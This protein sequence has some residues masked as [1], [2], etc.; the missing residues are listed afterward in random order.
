MFELGKLRTV[1]E[2]GRSQLRQGQGS[3]RDLGPD[4]HVLERRV[5][6]PVE[7]EVQVTARLCSRIFGLTRLLRDFKQLGAGTQH[8]VL[9]DLA[10]SKQ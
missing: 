8:L 9:R 1:G 4:F 7:Q 6:R 5:Q 2:R 10:V 3:R